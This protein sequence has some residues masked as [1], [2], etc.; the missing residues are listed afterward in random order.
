MG[1]RTSYESGTFSWADLA[2]TDPAGAKAFYAGLF[3]WE[4]DDMPVG[5]GGTYTM[6]R[7]DGKHVAALSGQRDE[8]RD[9]GVPPHW[10]NYVTVHD[11][12]ARAPRIAELNGNLMMP[13]F[14]VMDAG[15]MA[16]ATDPTGAVFMLWEPKNHIGAGLVNAPGALS[17]NEL[18]TTDVATAK[19]FYESLFGWT[20]EEIDM[21]GAGTY[22][23]IR[24]GDRSNGGIRAQGPQEQGVPPNWMPYFG[25]VSCEESAARAA[26]VG[27]RVIVPTMRV[28]AGAF[29]AVADPQ[30]AVFSIFE[31]DFDD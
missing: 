4:Y 3:G 2:T 8:E 1:E 12:D 7:V 13:P 23:I 6:C 29:A 14:D 18:A 26:E 20:Y 9:Q 15:R 21:N 5:G 10:N 16:V 27:G 19:Q 11:I 24:N 25:A 31:G 17:W 22:T 28:P 30:G